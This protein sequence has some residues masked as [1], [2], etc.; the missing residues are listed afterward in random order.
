MY[1][2]GKCQRMSVWLLLSYTSFWVYTI[3]CAWNVSVYFSVLYL[4]ALA[5]WRTALQ[6]K[7]GSLLW[8]SAS[9]VG[10]TQPWQTCESPP[11]HTNASHFYT[12]MTNRLRKLTSKKKGIFVYEAH[13]NH[14][15]STRVH[16]CKKTGDTLP[17]P[18][19]YSAG[20]CWLLMLLILYKRIVNI[21]VYTELKLLFCEKK[22]KC[23]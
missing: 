19:S 10:P 7:P 9:G 18:R 13:K 14:S 3:K 21:C 16:K 1:A 6:D 5:W 22:T 15:K 20:S 8:W 2:V 11:A 12:D 4:T 17:V 23:A